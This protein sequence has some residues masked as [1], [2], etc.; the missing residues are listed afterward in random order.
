MLTSSPPH[1]E[2]PAEPQRDSIPADICILGAG[3]GGL[4]LAAAAAA[5][6]QSVVLIEKHKMGGT[7]LNYGSMPAKALLASAERAQAFR[8]AAPFGIASFE[9]TI[10]RIVIEA[11]IREIVE[12]GVPNASVERMT[13]LGVRV[14]QA[15]GRFIDPKTIAA[16]E[17]KIAARRFV[18]ATGS[19]PLVPAIPGLNDVAYFT[20]ETVFAQRGAI[21][22]LIVIGGGAA[23]VEIAQAHRRLGARVTILHRSA[24]PLRGFDPDLVERLVARTCALGVDVRDRKSVV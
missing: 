10:D 17:H 2:T 5:Y 7:S 12:T 19:S 24:R 8:T 3:P 21:D 14:I 9:P 16:G 15:A 6:G 18:I 11:Q 22:H 23:G 4:A 1:A 20:T 13:G